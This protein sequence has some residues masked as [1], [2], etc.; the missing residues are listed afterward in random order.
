MALPP[1][2]PG[3]PATSPS[4]SDCFLPGELEDF[5][6]TIVRNQISGCVEGSVAPKRIVESYAVYQKDTNGTLVNCQSMRAN[7]FNTRF[8]DIFLN[9]F[10]TMADLTER[11]PSAANVLCV[12]NMLYDWASSDAMTS[13]STAGTINQSQ[14]D[15]MWTV[16]GLAATYFKFPHL[17]KRAEGQP[18]G[19]TNKDKVIKSWLLGLGNQISAEIDNNQAAGHEANTQYWRGF[20]ILPIALLNRNT[21]LLGK[22]RRVFQTALSAI[23]QPS[24]SRSEDDS[25]FLPLELQRY[26]KALHYH[27]FAIEPILAS[28]IY[29][30]AYGCNFVRS[31]W[32]VDQLS[33]L[34]R[35]TIQGHYQRQVFTDEIA[36]ALGVFGKVQEKKDFRK[37][38]Y[39]ADGFNP[40]ISTN[41]QSFIL[42]NQGVN[43]SKSFGS[44]S[45]NTRIGGS[46]SKIFESMEIFKPVYSGLL[47]TACGGLSFPQ[48]NYSFE[49]GKTISSIVPTL[50]SSGTINNCSVSPAL[51]PGLVISQTN[52]AISGRP[53]A[54][55]AKRKYKVTGT[56]ANPSLAFVTEI[57][58][59][60]TEPAVALNFSCT[61]SNNNNGCSVNAICPVGKVI[62]SLKAACDLEGTDIT[63]SS[64]QSVASNK[65]SVLRSSDV[66]TDGVC[67]VGNTSIQSGQG[68]LTP[69]YSNS[70]LASCRERD[71]N[72]GDCKIVLEISCSSP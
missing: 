43:L 23:M 8:M 21:A 62:K 44:S 6:T 40:T 45:S 14:L 47:G 61:I 64:L 69:S 49:T 34:T 33:R 65:V 24:A 4:R 41:I 16:A 52:C 56:A 53:T 72:G 7:E 20:S 12:S 31:N 54:V 38:I 28:A 55:S 42:R 19:S 32:E 35:K 46:Y 22:S 17:Q 18:V 57:D 66:V 63:T 30:Q 26:E 1:L 5:D 59:A 13:I 68:Q 10:S 36:R 60:I 58:L 71:N 48:T 50:N 11:D 3:I 37:F 70:V 25:G 67:S 51:P 39:L 15:R 9:E 27:G 2:P 29:S